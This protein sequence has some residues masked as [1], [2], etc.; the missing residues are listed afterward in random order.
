ERIADDWSPV[1]LFALPATSQTSPL[2]WALA[3]LLAIG[4]GWV[5]ARWGLRPDARR[6]LDP[7]KLALSLRSLAAVLSAVR[8]LPPRILPVLW[9][10]GLAAAG[11]PRARRRPAAACAI[12]AAFA[13]LGEPRLVTREAV[14][15]AAYY[16]RP[17][18][19]TKQYAHAV[20]LLADSGVRGNLYDDYTI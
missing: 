15:D 8:F 17:F 20:W 3:W 18:A 11:R 7:A 16:R 13:K 6:D 10:P 4:T 9:P 14:F 19:A 1:R 5:A 12:A 2:A